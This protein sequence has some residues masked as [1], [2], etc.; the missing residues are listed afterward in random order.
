MRRAD[1]H[2]NA[3][4]QKMADYRTNVRAQE[5]YEQAVSR[6]DLMQQSL[7]DAQKNFS[8]HP[9]L[10]QQGHDP[11]IFAN[12][13]QAT[14]DANKNLKAADIEVTLAKDK[15]NEKMV[16]PSQF[17]SLLSTVSSRLRH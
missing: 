13:A 11:Q 1:A 7:T 10:G 2:A 15:I 3:A 4:I 5:R 14:T 12:L 8:S 9:A 17:Q 16:P 6:R